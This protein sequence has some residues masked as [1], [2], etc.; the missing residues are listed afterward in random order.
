[1][2]TILGLN[3]NLRINLLNEHVQRTDD[4]I[5]ISDPIRH[6][7]GAGTPYPLLDNIQTVPPESLNQL[8]EQQRRVAHPLCIKSAME[9]AGPPG[10][11][12]TKT[13]TELTR[14]LLECTAYDIIVLSERNGAIDAIAEKFASNCLVSNSNGKI[15]SISD[16]SL[17]LSVM[18]Y[19]SASIGDYTK[20]FTLEEKMK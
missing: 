12:K 3:P 6:V 7:I 5:L 1:M 15:Q 19:G 20:M 4:Q 8:N 2:I 14:S 11:G 13:I 16:V 18:T 10:T 9:V 17:W